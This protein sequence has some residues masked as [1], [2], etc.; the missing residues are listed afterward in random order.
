MCRVLFIE[1][2]AE[3]R[4]L[5]RKGLGALGIEVDAVWGGE[6]GIEAAATGRFDCVLLDIMMPDMDGFEVCARL[7]A[8]EATAHLPVIILTARVDR[9]T[10]IRIAE[11]GADAFVP[12]PFQLDNLAEIIR[13]HVH[14]LRE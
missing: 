6:K 7:K 11:L 8:G 13:D 10:R 5:V 9:D 1:D 14:G 2:D 4:I 12:K 3:T